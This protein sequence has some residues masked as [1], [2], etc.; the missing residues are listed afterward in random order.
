MRIQETN[1]ILKESRN[2]RHHHQEEEHPG[3]VTRAW[4]AASS[5][6]EKLPAK[7]RRE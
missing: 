6:P 3:L 4:K 2:M 5:L 1:R 7:L